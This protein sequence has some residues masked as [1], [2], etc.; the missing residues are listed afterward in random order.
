MEAYSEE[1]RKPSLESSTTRH[2]DQPI[3]TGRSDRARRS[4]R[5]AGGAD[6]AGNLRATIRLFFLH[7]PVWTT[8]TKK[9]RKRKKKK[10]KKK[11]RREENYFNDDDDDE[12]DEDAG[13]GEPTPHLRGG[14]RRSLRSGCRAA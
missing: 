7:R 14:Q 3:S 5:T 1:G 11:K 13:D 2:D 12:E 9:K 10:K 8:T 6:T 4:D